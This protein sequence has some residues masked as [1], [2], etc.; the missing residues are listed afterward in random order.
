M[1]KDVVKAVAEQKAGKVEYRTEKNGIIHVSIG[2][3]SFTVD[4]IKENFSVSV[5]FLKLMQVL[6]GLIL[7]SLA[8]STTMGTV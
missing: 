2:K 5:L 1:T 8:I 6:K 4:Q 7:E 3:K